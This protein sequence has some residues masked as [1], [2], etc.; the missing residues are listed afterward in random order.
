MKQLAAIIL[1]L[2]A[3]ACVPTQTTSPVG[4]E[5]NANQTS[6]VGVTIDWIDWAKSDSPDTVAAR[7]R[8]RNGSK[9]IVS[10][11]CVK[12]ESVTWPR[13]AVQGLE[14]DDWNTA[15]ANALPDEAHHHSGSGSDFYGFQTAA[16]LPG[17][18]LEFS[19]SFPREEFSKFKQ[20]RIRIT[21]SCLSKGAS[22]SR[23][24]YSNGFSLLDAR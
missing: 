24:A 15:R 4:P 19:Y 8:L 11:P 9:E 2:I 17:D 10:I 7:F 3:V 6:A 12:A 23:D 16:F 18:V 22:D 21:I 20:V 13:F 5:T 14:N 1:L